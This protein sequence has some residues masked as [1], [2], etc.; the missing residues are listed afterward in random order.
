MISSR[1]QGVRYHQNNTQQTSGYATFRFRMD[2]ILFQAFIEN[3]F[4][5][6]D[7][8]KGKNQNFLQ[9]YVVKNMNM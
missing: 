7:I 8:K 6:Q 1:I 4:F 3:K 5:I 9:L 2:R